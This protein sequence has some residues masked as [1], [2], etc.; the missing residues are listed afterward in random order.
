MKNLFFVSMKFRLIG[1]QNRQSPMSPLLFSFW[2]KP[3]TIISV[4]EISPN[5]QL[6][7]RSRSLPQT[8][9]TTSTV[10]NAKGQDRRNSRRDGRTFG[11]TK[12]AL[13]SCGP[14]SSSFNDGMCNTTLTNS[15]KL[16]KFLSINN[17]LC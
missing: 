14:S 7:T 2:I 8:C 13:T 11:L 3:G 6:Q 1:V 4:G 10:Q 16:P 15:L 17:F 5:H 12:P 9:C